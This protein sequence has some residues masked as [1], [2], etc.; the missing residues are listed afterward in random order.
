MSTSIFFNGN[1]YTWGWSNNAK[2]KKITSPRIMKFKSQF[3]KLENNFEDKNILYVLGP[4]LIWNFPRSQH[5]SHNFHHISNEMRI[6]FNQNIESDLK[7]KIIFRNYPYKSY[8]GMR[9]LNESNDLKNLNFS[10]NKLLAQDVSQSFL[11]IFDHLSTANLECTITGKPFF[12]FFKLDNYFFSN[13]GFKV[14]KELRDQKILQE[15]PVKFSKLLS[16]LNYENIKDWWFEG[17]REQSVNNFINEYAY[18]SDT[19]IDDWSKL[20]NSENNF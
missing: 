12:L 8:D 1:L 18:F 11:L 9:N 19:A 4:S 2:E 5:I 17:K 10:K 20:I 13:K 6:K 16:T 14:L 7:K 3:N 15:D